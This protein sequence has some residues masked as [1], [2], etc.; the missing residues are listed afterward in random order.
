MHTMPAKKRSTEDKSSSSVG[1]V[2]TNKLYADYSQQ[3][4]VTV[5]FSIVQSGWSA[6]YLDFFA[7]IAFSN[8]KE[9]MKACGCVSSLSKRGINSSISKMAASRT[10][11]W[12]RDSISDMSV[13]HKT[14]MYET[15]KTCIQ[16]WVFPAL[17]EK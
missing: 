8:R 15:Y 5:H 4:V 3:E 7:R 11:N 12:S 6:R 10:P 13:V 17:K 1:T 14:V 9:T 2:S 16:Q